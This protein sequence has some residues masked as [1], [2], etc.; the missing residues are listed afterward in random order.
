VLYAF[1]ASL[2]PGGSQADL[3]SIGF[4]WINN[5]RCNLLNENAMSGIENPARPYAITA[6]IIL[7]FGILQFLFLCANRLEKNEKWKRI[8]QVSSALSMV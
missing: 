2:Y 4:D 5:Y 6:M 8:I 7:C 1:S 3:D